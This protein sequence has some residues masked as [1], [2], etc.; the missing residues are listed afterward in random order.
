VF[1]QVGRWALNHLRVNPN[2]RS[3]AV[4]R[5]LPPILDKNVTLL[6]GKR[7]KIDTGTGTQPETNTVSGEVG[8]IA[9]E[10]KE[11]ALPDFS[12]LGMREVLKRGRA[13]GLKVHLVGTGL[14]VKQQPD[15]GTPL[16]EVAAVR[17][18]FRPP[19]KF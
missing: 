11:G 5:A 14:A 13:L 17:I 4:V 19:G 12:G 16:Q 2:K 7:R 15:A 6:S 10:L 18:S 3:S 8:R 1:R 9:S